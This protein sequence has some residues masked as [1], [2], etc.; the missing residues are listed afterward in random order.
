MDVDKGIKANSLLCLRTVLHIV[1]EKVRAVSN[2]ASVVLKTVRDI[3]PSIE[4]NFRNG[5]IL[6]IGV[7]SAADI[8]VSKVQAGG[9]RDCIW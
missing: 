2:R 4:E 9:F 7:G 3:R 1:R 5:G 8:S 6:R